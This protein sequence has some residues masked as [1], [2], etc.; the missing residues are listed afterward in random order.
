MTH[1]FSKKSKINDISKVP[2]PP[3]VDQIIEDLETAKPD[4]IVFTT[5]ISQVGLDKIYD[6]QKSFSL[7]PRF[8]EKDQQKEGPN[9]QSN[10]HDE[11]D[12]L[13]EQVIQFNQN[14]E[15]LAH[16]QNTLPKVLDNLKHLHEEL[17]EDKNCVND[18]YKQALEL[19][20]EI[21]SKEQNIQ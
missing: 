20:Q 17:N 7:P 19:H 1:M 16:L 4:D 15:K 10:D 3:T 21:N 14:V 12:G 18:T 11:L 6:V 13:Y 2:Q 9:N 5:D 8:Q